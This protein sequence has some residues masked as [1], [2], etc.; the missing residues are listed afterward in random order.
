MQLVGDIARVFRIP[1]HMLG[2]KGDGQT[3]QNVEQASLNFLTHTVQPWL[4][5]IEVLLSRLLPDGQEF[6]FD[7]SALLRLDA[8]TKAR[9][10]QTYVMMGAKSPNEVRQGLGLEPYDGGDAFNQALAGSVTAGGSFAPSLGEDSD[11]SAPVL[12]VV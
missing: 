4:R 2:V 11:P 6:V 10:D 9:V 1:A 7:T 3:Y 8:T 12:G 5:R